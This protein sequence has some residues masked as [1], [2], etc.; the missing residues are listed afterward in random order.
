MMNNDNFWST[1]LRATIPPSSRVS[2][3]ARP[4]PTS[5][6]LVSAW[7]F[8]PATFARRTTSPYIQHGYIDLDD[9]RDGNDYDVV[10]RQSGTDQAPEPGGSRVMTSTGIVL[11]V[12]IV[13][14]TIL[15]LAVLVLL[16]LCRYDRAYPAAPAAADSVPAAVGCRRYLVACGFGPSAAVRRPAVET[17]SQPPAATSTGVVTRTATATL[18]SKSDRLSAGTVVVTSTQIK[19]NRIQNIASRQGVIEWFV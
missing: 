15:L 14:A 16:V 18:P 12:S 11:V 9:I 10:V 3:D 13:V 8:T 6:Q 4:A 1:T 7:I 19:H 5:S 2:D 17:T